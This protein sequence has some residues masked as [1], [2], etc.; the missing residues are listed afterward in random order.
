MLDQFKAVHQN[1]SRIPNQSRY[2]SH[3]HPVN[4][5]REGNEDVWGAVS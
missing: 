5:G 3:G 4:R 2:Y 1:I